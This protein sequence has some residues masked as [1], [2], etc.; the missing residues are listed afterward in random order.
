[1]QRLRKAGDKAAL[2]EVSQ[3]LDPEVRRGVLLQAGFWQVRGR[4]PLRTEVLSGGLGGEV[5]GWRCTH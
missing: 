5:G 4:R 2:L 3:H 1:M